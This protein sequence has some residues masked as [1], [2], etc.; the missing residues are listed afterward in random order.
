MVTSFGLKAD[1]QQSACILRQGDC[2]YDP[3]KKL[4]ELTEPSF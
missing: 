2:I 3:K 1:S 4:D